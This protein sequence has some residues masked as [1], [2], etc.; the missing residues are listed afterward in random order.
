MDRICSLCPLIFASAR[1]SP[2]QHAIFSQAF[3][4]RLTNG[5][6]VDSELTPPDPELSHVTGGLGA[7][8]RTTVKLVELKPKSPA[9][10]A[11][12]GNGRIQLTSMLLPN[13]LQVFCFNCYGWVKG[14]H[15][16]NAAART[17]DMIAAILSELQY[18]SQELSLFVVT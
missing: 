16:D 12:I 2:S 18:L 5:N 8:A 13:N 9:L 6:G 10:Q 3:R 15:D 17:D 7:F 1:K 4:H 11:I 14:D